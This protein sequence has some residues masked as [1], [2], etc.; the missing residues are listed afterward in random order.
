M[1]ERDRKYGFH[2]IECV[3]C[4]AVEKLNH[5][6]LIRTVCRPDLSEDEEINKRWF[7]DHRFLNFRNLYCTEGR[8]SDWLST[9]SGCSFRVRALWEPIGLNTASIGLCKQD[10][11]GRQ[12][13]LRLHVLF[14]CFYPV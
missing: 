9:V 3:C 5:Q 13:A 4:S 10:T 1:G 7:L 8:D 2:R 14:I 12:I 11:E 6:L